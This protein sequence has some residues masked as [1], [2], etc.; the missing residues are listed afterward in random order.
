LK[1]RLEGVRCWVHKTANVLND[2]PKGKPP[3]A[4]SMPHDI[5]MPETKAEAQKACDLFVETF[6]AKYAKATERLAKGRE[7][8]LTRFLRAD[9]SP[10]ELKERVDAMMSAPALSRCRRPHPPGEGKR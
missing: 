1:F 7:V 9:L 3:K 10:Y 2:L 5:W 6:Q 8:L 4:K